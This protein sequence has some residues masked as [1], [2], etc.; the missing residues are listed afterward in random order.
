MGPTRG[1]AIFR[2]SRG[3]HGGGEEARVRR[4]D[5]GG[6][7][8]GAVGARGA[9][10]VRADPAAERAR[11]HVDEP[12]VRAALPRA[13][14]NVDHRALRGARVE[15]HLVGAQLREQRV[16]ERLGRVARACDDLEV[17]MALERVGVAAPLCVM[18][19]N[20]I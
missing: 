16:H 7:R 9:V 14:R 8:G 5:G 11:R 6:D 13:Q 4:G 15:P 12:R 18:S 2:P 1:G 20:V 19:S 17:A 10:A 3:R